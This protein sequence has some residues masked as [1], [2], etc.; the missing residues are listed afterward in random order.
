MSRYPLWITLKYRFCK[1][2]QQKFRD[3][4]VQAVEIYDPKAAALAAAL[5]G[6]SHLSYSGEERPNG[7]DKDVSNGD[8]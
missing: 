2:R 4:L 3:A 8:A 7:P 6:K 5:P 1:D